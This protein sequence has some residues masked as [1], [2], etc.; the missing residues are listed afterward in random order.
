MCSLKF[1]KITVHMNVNRKIIQK[2]SARVKGIHD[3]QKI[4]TVWISNLI[5]WDCQLIKYNDC[6]QS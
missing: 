4:L 5:I 6:V 2:I 1:N 3:T